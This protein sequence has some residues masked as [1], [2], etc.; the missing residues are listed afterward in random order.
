MPAGGGAGGGMNSPDRQGG[1]RKPQHLVPCTI[2]QILS[3]PSSD[4]VFRIDGRDTYYVKVVGMILRVARG[5]LSSTYTIDD[6]TGQMDCRIY[7]ES[8]E[9]G[10]AGAG[11]AAWIREQQEQWVEHSYIS[12]IGYM[13]SMGDKRALQASRIKLITD[14]NEITYHM[15][16]VAH[17]HLQATKGAMATGYF[18]SNTAMYNNGGYYGG[19]QDAMD[20]TSMSTTTATT[21]GTLDGY[22]INEA[23]LETVRRSGDQG[24][25]ISE[26]A[27]AVGRSVDDIRDVMQVL[28]G[29]GFVYNTLTEEHYKN[30]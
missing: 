3:Q 4:E 19:A 14:H 13:K 12:I 22:S 5:T 15:L 21:M 29:E 1:V 7:V 27:Q 9:S 26:I 2:R 30:T 20:T 11:A 6:G 17:A 16:D 25:H 28:M 24:L 18:N 8:S 23:I 10:A